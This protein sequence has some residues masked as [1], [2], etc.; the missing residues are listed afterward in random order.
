LEEGKFLIA[1]KMISMRLEDFKTIA[2]YI[3]EQKIIKRPG[4]LKAQQ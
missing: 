1:V 2:S 3:Q 4:P